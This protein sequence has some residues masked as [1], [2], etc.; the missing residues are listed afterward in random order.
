MNG[1]VESCLNDAKNKFEL[2]IKKIFGS[3]FCQDSQ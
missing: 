3:N 1:L 2:E